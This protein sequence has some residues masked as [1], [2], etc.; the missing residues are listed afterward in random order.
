MFTRGEDGVAPTLLLVTKF[1]HDGLTCSVGVDGAVACGTV[2]EGHLPRLEGRACGHRGA[3]NRKRLS[4]AHK[5]S[6]NLGGDR[7][8]AWTLRSM[9]TNCR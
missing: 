6:G 3:V 2:S 1:Q 5:V 8:T 7:C 9:T 4:A